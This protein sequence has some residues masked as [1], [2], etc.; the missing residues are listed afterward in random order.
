MT[1]KSDSKKRPPTKKKI[2]K[3]SPKSDSSLGQRI[4]H[5]M[6]G[7]KALTRRRGENLIN[8]GRT[9]AHQERANP[10]LLAQ[11]RKPG[12]YINAFED[13]FH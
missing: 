11:L 4:L 3:R 6:T 2:P 12:K 13:N 9:S 8:R 10:F 1:T 5:T 7:L